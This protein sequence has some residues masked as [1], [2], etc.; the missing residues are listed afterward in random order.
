MVQRFTNPLVTYHQEG[1]KHMPARPVFRASKALATRVAAH[2]REGI[3]GIHLTDVKPLFG[4][5]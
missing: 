3:T 1:T 2:I 5:G 4:E